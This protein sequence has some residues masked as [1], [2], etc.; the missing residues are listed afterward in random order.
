M[1]QPHTRTRGF[2]LIEILVVTFIIATLVGLLV[3]ALQAVRQ[4]TNIQMCKVNLKNIAVGLQTYLTQFNNF[5][6]VYREK[7]DGSW[8]P[9]IVLVGEQGLIADQGGYSW[10]QILDKL[11]EAD[12]QKGYLYTT[13]A[14]AEGSG[15]LTNIINTRG[16]S[17]AWMCPVTGYGRGIYMGTYAVFAQRTFPNQTIPHKGSL[18][19]ERIMEAGGSGIESKIPVCGD[20]SLGNSE[21][22]WMTRFNR[23]EKQVDENAQPG[24]FNTI[25]TAVTGR[26]LHSPL[27]GKDQGKTFMNI[28]F[29]HAG[30]AV[31]LYLGWN[32]KEWERPDEGPIAAADPASPYNQYLAQWDSMF[33]RGPSINATVP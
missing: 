10:Q 15:A 20:G 25:H 33:Y 2:T 24:P 8:Y 13:A 23:P 17:K 19:M 18:S 28:D 3:P 26:F 21:Q 30:K 31:V 1:K 7:T 6:P 5:L 29:R 16:A 9:G 12:N 27:Q 11:M 14:Y 4:R 32:I 22:S